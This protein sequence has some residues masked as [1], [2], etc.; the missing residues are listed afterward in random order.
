MVGC[1]FGVVVVGFEC[2]YVLDGCVSGEF[3]DEVVVD[4]V[5]ESWVEVFDCFD[6]V[7]LGDECV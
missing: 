5:V 3:E 7:L 1:I 4:C 6:C 2:W